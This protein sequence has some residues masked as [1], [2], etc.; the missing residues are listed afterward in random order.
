MASP[1]R[2]PNGQWPVW[3]YLFMLVAGVAALLSLVLLLVGGVRDH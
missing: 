1:P 2:Y 3:T